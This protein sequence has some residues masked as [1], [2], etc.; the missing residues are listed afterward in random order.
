[1][2][3]L[4]CAAT[5]VVLAHDVDE[6]GAWR[7]ARTVRLLHEQRVAV[8]YAAPGTG[9]SAELVGEQLGLPVREEPGL[10]GP[11]YR[12][13]LAAVADLHRGET[14]LV[15]LGVTVADDLERVLGHPSGAGE[16]PDGP[17]AV[18][19]DADGWVRRGLD[20]STN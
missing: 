3:D 16:V 10:D 12:E 13:G 8:V 2:S 20:Q 19:I 14:V 1:M 6:A 11:S 9:P 7:A 5:L 18:A 4:Q 17:F 15:V